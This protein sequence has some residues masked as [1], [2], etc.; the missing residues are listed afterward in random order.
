MNTNLMR[1]ACL[2]AAFNPGI[3]RHEFKDA[4]MRHCR[5]PG[6]WPH[7]PLHAVL[8]ASSKRETD[9][10]CIS[11]HLSMD[12]RHVDSLRFM[13]SNFLLEDRKCPGR[14]G[15]DHD[16]GRIL[17]Q[18]VNDARTKRILACFKK[19]RPAVV[20]KCIDKRMIRIA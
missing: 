13:R 14:L 5:F 1:P 17:V 7:V 19:F 11:F 4:E 10:A 18:T 8:C 16:T 12:E 2:K 20:Q 15:H 3:M 9:D 6:L